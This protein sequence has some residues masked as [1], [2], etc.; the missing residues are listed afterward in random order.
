MG[1]AKWRGGG[2]P[3]PTAHPLAPLHTAGA[4]CEVA[5]RGASGRG[6]VRGHPRWR[7]ARGYTRS[8]PVVASTAWTV[9]AERADVDQAVGVGGG[10]VVDGARGGEAPAHLAGGGV[11]G[12]QEAVVAAHDH[13]P[14][15]DQRAGPDAARRGVAPARTAGV[16]LQRVQA[17]VVAAHVQHAVGDRGRGDDPLLRREVPDPRAGAGVEGADL[18]VVAAD[19]DRLP[20]DPRRRVDRA[21][22]R[23]LPLLLAGGRV[24]AV[25]VVVA[26]ADVDDAVDDRGRG[27]E[28]AAARE[29]HRYGAGADVEGHAACSTRLP[30]ATRSPATAGEECTGP[31]VSVAQ[32][33]SPVR[34]STACSE[35]VLAADEQRAVGDPRRRRDRALGRVAPPL[36]AGGG[37]EGVEVVV[38][39]ADVDDAAVDQRRGVDL[40]AGRGRPGPGG[41][42]A[43]HRGPGRPARRGSPTAVPPAISSRRLLSRGP[44]RPAAARP[45]AAPRTA[46]PADWPP[47]PAA[48]ERCG[49]PAVRRC[50]RARA[51]SP[52][53]RRPIRSAPVP[54]PSRP[55]GARASLRPPVR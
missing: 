26:A 31:P 39:A 38:V 41:A 13:E 52:G 49:R 15:D 42:V 35:P 20:H 44:R 12:V 6:G 19:V 48:R 4:G 37:V 1:G 8:R 17:A 18:V 45:R 40:V 29:L 22:R 21:R 51:A 23:V 54:P 46:E 7:G 30:T 5:R 55:A 33:R 43:R 10:G 3:S 11:D 27:V 24:D 34:A 32:R 14:V 25:D 47:L 16:G 50:R 53:R 2:G 36:G 9:P 28:P